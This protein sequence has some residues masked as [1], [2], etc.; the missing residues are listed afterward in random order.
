MCA[1]RCQGGVLAA[2]TAAFF[3]LHW[4]LSQLLTALAALG[5]LVTYDQV[6]HWQGD[7]ACGTLNRGLALKD[8][9]LNL[10]AAFHL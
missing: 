2:L 5:F 1:P 10:M 3:G 4:E 8:V 9:Q 7:R 6:R